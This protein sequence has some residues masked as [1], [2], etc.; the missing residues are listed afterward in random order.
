[1][2]AFVRLAVAELAVGK[3]VFAAWV[4][5]NK[6]GSPGTPSARM[7]VFEDGRQ[8]GTIGGGIMEHELVQ[9][10]MKCLHSGT[11]LSPTVEVLQHR[12]DG[13]GNHSG[14]ICGGEQTQVLMLWQGAADLGIL[15]TVLDHI[16]REQAGVWRIRPSGMDLTGPVLP[17]GV[18]S[19]FKTSADSDWVLLY[20]LINPRRILICGGGHCGVAAARL[21]HG[22]GYAVTLLE[23]REDVR[24]LAHLPPGVRV[25]H[26]PFHASL[27]RVLQPALTHSVVMTHSLATDIE[28]L[29]ALLGE[30][31]LD[32]AVMGSTAKIGRIHA[33]LMQLGH[34]KSA[35]T[36]ITAPLGLA[37]DSDTPE[38]IAV[39]L[40]A[41]IL[42][43]RKRD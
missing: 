1:M 25:L 42:L 23:P 17:A 37:M 16:R 3:P 15:E 32:I 40:A 4:V 30:P 39:S 31:F 9:G 21:M 41:R 27:Q 38:E 2:E 28:A 26:G 43:A 11:G 22:L 7:L 35:L 34:D 29:D 14:L 13:G 20:N 12:A 24:T 10:A 18:S 33:A 5:A 6:K 19:E 36:R 8:Y